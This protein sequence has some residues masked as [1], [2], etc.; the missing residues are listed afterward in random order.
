LICK[1]R[2]MNYNNNMKHALNCMQL[3]SYWRDMR[4]MNIS[5]VEPP[6]SAL[7]V[8]TKNARECVLMAYPPMYLALK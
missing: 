4:V 7:S 6:G 3:M 1:S 5:T 2:S 8:K